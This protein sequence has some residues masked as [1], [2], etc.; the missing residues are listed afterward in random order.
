MNAATVSLLDDVE[1]MRE[2]LSPIRL[3]ML[4]ALRTPGSAASLASVLDVPRQKV[5]YHLRALEAA[6]LVVLVEERARRGFTE[7]LFVA[8]AEAFVVDPAILQDGSPDR[9]RV[10]DRHAAEHLIG[11]AS[12]MVREVTR[13]RAAADAEGA[14][15]LTFTLESRVAFATPQAMEAFTHDLAKALADLVAAYDTPQ[16]GRAYSLTLGGHP[17]PRGKAAAAIN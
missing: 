10:Q 2:A 11:A 1:R 4:R 7:R 3:K 13:M 14:R 8:S 9:A 16:G 6:G 12:E 15:L 17:T 5:G